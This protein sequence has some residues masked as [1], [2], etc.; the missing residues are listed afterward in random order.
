MQPTVCPIAQDD[1]PNKARRTTRSLRTPPKGAALNEVSDRPRRKTRTHAARPAETACVNAGS[2]R[3]IAERRAERLERLVEMSYVLWTVVARH[4]LDKDAHGRL[5]RKEHARMLW[6]GVGVFLLP[7][8]PLWNLVDA[9]GLT[10]AGPPALRR[11]AM[12]AS[13]R[14]LESALRTF[15]W[16]INHAQALE[17]AIEGLCCGRRHSHK[18]VM[19]FVN[20]HRWEADMYR[21]MNTRGIMNE[22]VRADRMELTMDISN[23][24]W[25]RKK[26]PPPPGR[27]RVVRD[28]DDYS[29]SADDIKFS[30]SF[31]KQLCAHGSVVMADMMRDDID[32]DT[33]RP[34]FWKEL[35]HRAC[36]SGRTAVFDSLGDYCDLVRRTVDAS[37]A[38]LEV[39]KWCSSNKYPHAAR[40][41]E[42]LREKFGVR[43]TADYKRGSVEYVVLRDAS[44]VGPELEVVDVVVS[45][46][47][48]RPAVYD[49]GTEVRHRFTGVILFTRP[50]ETADGAPPIQAGSA[51][52]VAA[53]AGRTAEPTDGGTTTTEA[54][55]V[56]ELLRCSTDR[57]TNSFVVRPPAVVDRAKETT[58]DEERAALDADDRDRTTEAPFDAERSPEDVDVD[59]GARCPEGGDSSGEG[60]TEGTGDDECMDEEG[61]M[62]GDE[63]RYGTD[64][65]DGEGDTKGASGPVPE[66]T[67]ARRRTVRGIDL[68]DAVAALDNVHL[69]ANTGRLVARTRNGAVVHVAASGDVYAC[70]AKSVEDAHAAI[71][72]VGRL[73]AEIGYDASVSDRLVEKIVCRRGKPKLAKKKQDGT[74]GDGDAP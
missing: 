1:T 5:E 17:A 24:P 20:R 36:R 3:T 2:K 15:S 7:V 19:A 52:V 38:A 58:K 29:P 71:D 49:Y 65:A 33:L 73:L 25:F 57:S 50:K 55:G 30:R 6:D 47:Y 48:G 32:F 63:C 64:G 23:S 8:R 74:R 10:D 12:G 54:G 45:A 22:C 9:A 61:G 44:A 4:L 37:E 56:D 31:A 40:V 53:T 66:E 16:S 21:V 62:D 60:C 28:Y 13:M 46:R 18:A 27:R 72:E 41:L 68:R 34:A 11:L 35:L 70:G 26:R 43:E 59:G 14:T 67:V 51:V 69:N 39:A 42:W